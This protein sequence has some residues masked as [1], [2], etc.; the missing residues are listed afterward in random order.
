MQLPHELPGLERRHWQEGFSYKIR[1]SPFLRDPW[2]FHRMRVL[3]RRNYA[4]FWRYPT[5]VST[6]CRRAAGIVAVPAHGVGRQGRRIK[7]A[8]ARPPMAGHA[9]DAHGLAAPDPPALMSPGRCCR[10]S[11]IQSWG[12]GERRGC[13]ADLQRCSCCS[14]RR[15][16]SGG[17]T[18]RVP[19]PRRGRCATPGIAARSGRPGPE[20]WRLACRAR[21]APAPPRG[22]PKPML[23][24][25][26]RAGDVTGTPLESYRPS[27]AAVPAPAGSASCRAGARA[28]NQVT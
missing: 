14:R 15:M 2:E 19:R 18:A 22:A 11:A 10:G 7:A 1:R 6:A 9:W 23:R 3:G 20:T 8:T 17:S 13:R 25:G 26:D 27:L 12:H 16:D 28:P 21:L 4:D 5:K 24:R